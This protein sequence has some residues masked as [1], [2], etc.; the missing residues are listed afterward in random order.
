M[1]NH[2]ITNAV[3]NISSDVVIMI[4]PLPLVFKVQLPMKNKLILGAI[5]LVGFFTVRIFLQPSISSRLVKRCTGHGAPH[6][7]YS[8][9][10]SMEKLHGRSFCYVVLPMLTH[11]NADFCSGQEQVRV[12]YGSLCDEV[13][14]MVLPRSLHRYDM[15]QSA[16]H[17]TCSPASL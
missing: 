6:S 4:I 1:I 14:H 10:Q 17:P 12:I 7:R 15:R 3:L 16:A 11:C 2:L 5:F 8:L 9:S 13:D